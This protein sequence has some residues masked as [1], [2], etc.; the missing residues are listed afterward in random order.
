MRK[1]VRKISNQCG[2]FVMKK[3]NIIIVAIVLIIFTALNGTM[4]F[5]NYNLVAD[6]KDNP[7]YLVL[8]DEI[9]Q[10]QNTN[11]QVWNFK[12][13]ETGWQLMEQDQVHAMRGRV[14]RMEGN[15]KTSAVIWNGQAEYSVETKAED[16][17]KKGDELVVFYSETH[18]KLISPGSFIHQYGY[19]KV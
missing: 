19:I 15:D 4:L 9:D 17:I 11:M 1:K 3:K 2:R 14:E 5:Y 12:D 6:E 18:S 13:E 7:S 8:E 10:N 16:K